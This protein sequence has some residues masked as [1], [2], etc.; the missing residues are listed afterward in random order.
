MLIKHPKLSVSEFASQILDEQAVC[1]YIVWT[2]REEKGFLSVLC[3]SIDEDAP[4]KP[5]EGYTGRS[6]RD[7]VTTAVDDF[8]VELKNQKDP[9][10][11]VA[12]KAMVRRRGWRSAYYY[13][14]GSDLI[15]QKIGI[16]A[17]YSKD[18]YAFR[19]KLLLARLARFT[20][21]LKEL[22]FFHTSY[23]MNEENNRL[24][25]NLAKYDDLLPD[26]MAARFAI[27]GE[28][29]DSINDLGMA[30]R[31]LKAMITSDPD[32]RK[33]LSRKLN[34]ILSNLRGVNERREIMR[35]KLRKKKHKLS[36]LVRLLVDRFRP[37][38]EA[39][40]IAFKVSDIKY[41]DG[42]AEDIDL[43]VDKTRFEQVFHN[44]IHNSIYHITKDPNLDRKTKVFE[45]GHVVGEIALEINVLAESVK[46]RLSDS[47]E[48][49]DPGKLKHVMDEFFSHRGTDVEQGTGFGL[50]I[51]RHYIEAH[52]G[53]IK[54][55]S[56]WGENFVVDFLL[57]L[58]DE[59]GK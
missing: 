14:L 57:P 12:L 46:F 51:A 18:S 55:D 30:K 24:R 28:I 29:H 9:N 43:L 1:D 10:R 25:S 7:G 19:H 17:V 33:E 3:S 13:T 36:R 11:K 59:V 58:D 44:L 34:S 5:G 21:E 50:A 45:S 49:C 31:L 15:C 40:K 26:L 47:G 52:K 2:Y 16:Y 42:N 27:G 41:R 37:G 22:I 4:I 8:E 32:R 56:D 20:D 38:I 48:G 23:G 35:D 39:N 53:A 6:F 54:V